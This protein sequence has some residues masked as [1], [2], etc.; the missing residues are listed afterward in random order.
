MQ[1]HIY[2]NRGKDCKKIKSEFADQI[3]RARNAI[4]RDSEQNFL[5]WQNWCMTTKAYKQRPNEGEQASKQVAR[6]L[7]YT[8][9][10]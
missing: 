3:S 9:V 6:T 1:L 10:N 4:L 8:F 5:S 7:S 2:T